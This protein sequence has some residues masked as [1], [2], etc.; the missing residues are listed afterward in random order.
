MK[1]VLFLHLPTGIKIIPIPVLSDNYS[2][3]VIDTAS[4]VAVVVDPADPQTVQVSASRVSL[5]CQ[6]HACLIRKHTHTVL[7]VFRLIIDFQTD[8]DISL[9]SR[10][11]S[12]G[13]GNSWSNVFSTKKKLR[14]VRYHCNTIWVTNKS[15]WL[16][17]CVAALIYCY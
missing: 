11:F 4:S 10:P 17:A 2:Y 7:A 6:L 5:N 9:C 16:V 3:L 1:N 13:R 14:Q 15:L 12:V 8:T